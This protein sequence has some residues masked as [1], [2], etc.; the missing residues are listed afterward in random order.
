MNSKQSII[1]SGFVCLG[2]ILCGILGILDY[3]V[4]KLILGGA[5]M[6]MLF[7]LF[8]YHFKKDKN[9]GENN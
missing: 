5:F 8:Y 9:K 3:F 2:F 6:F 4:I 7:N 1:L